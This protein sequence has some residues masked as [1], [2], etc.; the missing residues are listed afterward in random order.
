MG[1]GPSRAVINIKSLLLTIWDIGR[2]IN[3]KEWR[4]VGHLDPKAT[5]DLPV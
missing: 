3:V 2:E 5:D 4:F 1:K